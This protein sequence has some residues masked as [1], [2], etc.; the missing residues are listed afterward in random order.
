MR[1]VMRL[2]DSPFQLIKNGTK[3]I[4]MR[5]NDE[6]RQELKV[7]DTINFINRI[8]EEEME[9]LITNLYHFKDFKEMYD[10]FDKVSVGYDINDMAKPS[11]MGQYYDK[12]DIAKYGTLAIE[13][14]LIKK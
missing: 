4:E 10:A 5:L 13:M 6:K 7:D 11:D 3:T 14:K 2:H 9:V 8:S 1:H 12:D